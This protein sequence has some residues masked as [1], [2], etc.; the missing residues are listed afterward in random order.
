MNKANSATS[1]K[2]L[3]N[4]IHYEKIEPAGNLRIIL[5]N[6]NVKKWGKRIAIAEVLA[7]IAPVPPLGN[8]GFVCYLGGWILYESANRHVKEEYLREWAMKEFPE[9]KNRDDEKL[10]WLGDYLMKAESKPGEYKD[11]FKNSKFYNKWVI[12]NNN[13]P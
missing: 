7:W 8:I 1:D 11:R 6:P 2:N 13:G 4:L 3:E 5:K 9:M 10:R 12:S